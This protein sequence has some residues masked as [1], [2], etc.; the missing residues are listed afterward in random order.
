METLPHQHQNSRLESD[1]YQTLLSQEFSLQQVLE[2]RKGGGNE[3]LK[4]L[5]SFLPATEFSD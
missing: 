3:S 2:T 5:K 4:S 1:F